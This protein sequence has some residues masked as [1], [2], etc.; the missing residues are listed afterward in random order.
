MSKELRYYYFEKVAILLIME[1]HINNLLLYMLWYNLGHYI[2]RPVK[3]EI[4]RIWHRLLKRGNWDES[5]PRFQSFCF[6]LMRNYVDIHATQLCKLFRHT[7]YV[8]IC[9][10]VNILII[11]KIHFS[12]NLFSMLHALSKCKL[13][14]F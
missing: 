11:I 5:S 1:K 9:C 10:Q 6:M 12:S 13:L 8:F 7:K 3:G 14:I 2:V 4:L